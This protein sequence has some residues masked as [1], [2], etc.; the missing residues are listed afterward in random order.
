MQITIQKT[1]NDGYVLVFPNPNGE[2]EVIEC[3][4]PK[5]EYD[6]AK[7]RLADCEC[8]KTVLYTALEALDAGYSKHSPFN[9]VIRIENEE[10]V[11]VDAH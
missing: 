6:S 10:G 2:G 3:Y 9:V 11:P 8:V 7:S 5:E 1:D 4:S